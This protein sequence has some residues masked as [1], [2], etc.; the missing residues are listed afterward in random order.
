MNRMKNTAQGVKVFGI[1][2][3]SGMGKTT[4]LE[5]LIPQLTNRGLRVSLIKHSHKDIEIDQ[6]GK[7]S[8]RLRTAGCHEVLLMGKSRWALMHEQSTQT[9]PA[10]L[11]LLQRMQKCDLVLVEGFKQERFP[12]IEVYR[13][14]N[15]KT[16]L[17]MKMQ[18]IVGV[19]TDVG[20]ATKHDTR[21]LPQFD[22]SDVQSIANFVV[23]Q[24]VPLTR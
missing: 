22:L 24:A 8:F 13:A 16:P 20:V 5:K 11:Y 17:W 4:L 10:F 12:K 21:K 14:I 19:A 23:Q 3:H 9:E 6:P 2:G 1:A 18:D 7:D 15:E